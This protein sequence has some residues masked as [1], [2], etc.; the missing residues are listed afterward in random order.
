MIK[1]TPFCIVWFTILLCISCTKGLYNNKNVASNTRQIY[2]ATGDSIINA[3]S[4]L[5]NS[6]TKLQENKMYFWYYKD[7]INTSQGNYYGQLLHGEYTILDT[8]T[9]TIISKGNF[10]KGLKDGKWM[11]WYGNGKL[12]ECSLWDNGVQ[13]GKY[14]LFDSNG[15]ILQEY[16]VKDREKQLLNKQKQ[17]SVSKTDSIKPS[18]YF[19]NRIFQ[20]NKSAKNNK[21]EE[22]QTETTK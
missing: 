11:R 22:K 4:W 5:G 13:V 3:F 6:P 18:G 2:I 12:K 14:T 20:K 19:W 21:Q 1:F 17:V 8:K 9:K 16:T 15:N 10:N 7:N